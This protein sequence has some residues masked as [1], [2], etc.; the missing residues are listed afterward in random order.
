MESITNLVMRR[1]AFTIVE[2]LVTI[3]VVALLIGLLAPALHRVGVSSRSMKCQSNLKQMA[4]AAQNYAAIYDSWPEAI[5]YV[6][7]RRICWDWVT[8]NA[9]Q[10][11]SPGALWSFTTNPTE[12]HQCPE[13]D[14]SSTFTGDPY[15]GYNYNT[16]YL[17]TEDYPAGTEER[18]G[19][20]PHACGR[21]S[22]CAMFGDGAFKSGANKFMRAPMRREGLHLQMGALYSG[23][24]A[25]RHAGATHVAYV[26]GH[27]APVSKP[28][29]GPLATPALLGQMDF[30]NNG[31]LSNDDAAY[32]P[33]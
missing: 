28:W 3:A 9:G 11:I 16:S 5:R 25:F 30:P 26:D 15:T 14:G 8:T 2:L 6:P 29:P 17:G 18:R 13:F 4:V 12:V 20:P 7:G 23:G 33:N 1:S 24:Q 27:V 31:F 22:Q 32:S 21:S 10:L 19:T